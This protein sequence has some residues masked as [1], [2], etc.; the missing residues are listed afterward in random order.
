MGIP[1]INGVCQRVDKLLQ[2]CRHEMTDGG[3]RRMA[4]AQD[5][6]NLLEAMEKGENEVPK[7]KSVKA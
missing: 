5:T 2:T 7:H 1:E 4:P 6:G 3:D